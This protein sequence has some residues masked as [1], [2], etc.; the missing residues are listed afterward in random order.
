MG[1]NL[2]IVDTSMK[3]NEL[4]TLEISR[5]LQTTDTGHAEHE[6]PL[7]GLE[8]EPTPAAVLL[9]LFRS[10]GR[11]RVLYIRRATNQAD[12]HSG[13][14]AFPGGRIEMEDAD[15]DAA[16]LREAHEEIALHPRRVEL[17]GR[18]PS[19]RT[20]SNYLVNPV[21]GTIPWPLD[22][23]PDEREVARIFSIPLDWLADR[24]N[25]AIRPWQPPGYR[26]SR[27]VVFYREYDGE[28]LWGVSGRITLSLLQSLAGRKEK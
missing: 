1:P 11:W 26:I 19:F 7:P 20:A 21:V 25:Y 16:A 9:A 27:D 4:D 5:R 24:A 13:E 10:Q 22:L 3:M 28:R 17:I 12:R 2:C 8:G 18:L 14:V 6:S 15:P 23:S